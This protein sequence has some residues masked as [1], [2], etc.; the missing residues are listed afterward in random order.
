ML[1]IVLC[2]WV[3]I[4]LTIMTVVHVKLMQSFLLP[5]S[6]SPKYSL[7]PH[8]WL[9]YMNYFVNF[10]YCYF[11]GLRMWTLVQALTGETFVKWS[12][13]S[14]I[15]FPIE[16]EKAT[17]WCDSALWGCVKNNF[18]LVGQPWILF[19]MLEQMF[20]NWL[21][22]IFLSHSTIYSSL[23]VDWACAS[24]ITDGIIKLILD[25][26]VKTILLCNGLC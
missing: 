19:R 20:C 4:Y 12:A 18:C 25:G 13:L 17:S 16:H 22:N 14:F 6:R 2:M 21:L 9:Q 5:Y 24:F 23:D 7:I 26:V 3:Y 8:Y 11:L 1:G 15:H 10:I